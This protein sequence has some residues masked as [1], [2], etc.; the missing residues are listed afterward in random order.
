MSTYAGGSAQGPFAPAPSDTDGRAR[1]DELLAAAAREQTGWRWTD[2]HD[3]LRHAVRMARLAGVRE[4]E[5]PMLNCRRMLA[6]TLRELGRVDQAREMVMP[7]LEDCRVYAGPAHPVTVR[8]AAVAGAVLHDLGDLDGA[9]QLYHGL[10]DTR[11][12][13]D[14]SAARAVMLARV[15]LA[16][17]HRD[18]GNLAGALGL[19]CA[20]FAEFRRR[21]GND[22][23][24]TIRISVELADLYRQCGDAGNARRLLTVAHASAR[25]VFGDR[26][27]LTSVVKA[28]LA[29]TEPAV[30]QAPEEPGTAGTELVR[31]RPAQPPMSLRH[32]HAPPRHPLAGRVRAVALAGLAA[33][34]RVM[35]AGRVRG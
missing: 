9:E 33:G 16:L 3:M 15:N 12:V 30:P 34:R 35:K 18:R 7:L 13:T 1:L 26:H 11:Q 4:T 22:D 14:G 25:A 2:A 23:L 29:E 28:E 19:L 32:H 5:L 24:D 27:R 31:R 21:Y 10:V 6:E 17:L 8:T 20:V